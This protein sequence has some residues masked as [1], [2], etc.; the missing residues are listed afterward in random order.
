MTNLRRTLPKIYSSQLKL[1]LGLFIGFLYALAMYGFLYMSRETFRLFAV[2]SEYDLPILNTEEQWFYNLFAGLLAGVLAQSV[3]FRFWFDRPL[4]VFSSRDHRKK[5]MLND[6]GVLPWYFLHWMAKIVLVIANFFYFLTS[7]HYALSFYPRYRYLFVIILLVLFLQPWISIRRVYKNK[8]FKMAGIA[9]SVIIFNAIA[10]SAIQWI[11][12]ERLNQAILSKNISYQY[13]LQLPELDNP[14]TYHLRDKDEQLYLVLKETG[15]ATFV[16][17]QKEY[18]A[19]ELI[20]AL[21]EANSCK[22]E[23]YQPIYKLSI[24]RRCAYKYV[25]QLQ[26]A[27]QQASVHRVCY[28]V[29]PKQK[30]FDSRYY[31]KQVIWGYIPSQNIVP[32]LPD[33]TKPIDLITISLEGNK[34]IIN[35]DEKINNWTVDLR[36]MIKDNPSSLIEFYCDDSVI[37]QDYIRCKHQIKEVIRE[38]R[39]NY[40]IEKYGAKAD[41]YTYNNELLNEARIK[42]PLQIKEMLL[43]E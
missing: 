33:N 39:L 10:L 24:D 12:I 28:S 20:R 27:L 5:I 13:Q 38:L 9:F 3:V 26:K 22:R 42:Y 37:F 19:D 36:K 16:F 6:A 23:Y 11:D 4:T 41:F 29:L 8:A 17:N 1:W 14:E 34:I 18:N 31:T 25:F 40:L 30:E 15:V 43:F 35:Q 7:D 2:T 32:P 21:N